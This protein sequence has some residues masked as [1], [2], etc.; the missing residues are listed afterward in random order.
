MLKSLS[1][2]INSLSKNGVHFI[3]AVDPETQK[4]SVTL[5]FAYV[6]YLVCL[7]SI[8][9]LFFKPDVLSPAIVSI[10]VWVIS[11]VL[12]RMRRLDKLKVDLD[13]RSI[14]LDA[15]DEPSENK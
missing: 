1:E 12:Y 13:D 14:E 10:T 5:F 15:Q 2:F 7:F 8:A 6:T 4:P 3:Y 11:F 9:F